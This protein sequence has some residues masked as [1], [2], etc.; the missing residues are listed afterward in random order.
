MSARVVTCTSPAIVSQRLSDLLLDFPSAA[1]GGV[2]WQTLVRKYE[3]RHSSRL[4]CVALGHVTALSAATALLWDVV[5]IVDSDDKD[6]PIVA[7]EDSTAL[8]PRPG[9][10]ASWPSLYEVLV[11][12]LQQHGSAEVEDGKQVTSILVSQ[13]KPLLQ[14]HWHNNFDECCLGYLTEDGSAVKFKKMKHLLQALLRWREQ[15]VSWTSGN[16]KLRSAVDLIL[17]ARLELTPSKKHNDLLLRCVLPDRSLEDASSDNDAVSVTSTSL[18][19]VRTTSSSRSTEVTTSIEEELAA[20]RAENEKLRLQNTELK[21]HQTQKPFIQRIDDDDVFDNPFEPP[22]EVRSHYWASAP[23]P[24]GS[25]APG[26]DLGCFSSGGYGT[27][28][29][30]SCAAS[31][32]AT[33]VAFSAVGQGY[34]F[35]PVGWFAMGDRVE[36]PCGVVQQARAVFERHAVLPSWFVQR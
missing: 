34:T 15:R 20:L 26:S 4:D 25:T 16:S 10:A 22:P 13:L 28:H 14:Q 33:P 29:S 7:V 9:S 5:R 1:I 3:Q 35:V 23:S 11:S 31:G 24:I 27:P 36:I 18:T 8:M 19:E 6:N 30:G 17:D 12:V 2:Q 32:S 21:Q